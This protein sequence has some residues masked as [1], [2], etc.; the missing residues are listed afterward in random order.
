MASESF[1]DTTSGRLDLLRL[2][3][4]DLLPSDMVQEPQYMYFV[5]YVSSA[6]ADS[7]NRLGLP[8]DKTKVAIKSV[9]NSRNKLRMHVGD[10][11]RA[12]FSFD[13]PAA[14]DATRHVLQMIVR[15]WT[16]LDI[17]I[18]MPRYQAP[19]L[20]VWLEDESITAVTERFFSQ[21]AQTDQLFDLSG[22]VDPDLT[23]ARL[24]LDHN[25]RIIWTSNLAEHLSMNW[26]R[27]RRMLKVFEHK[28]WAHRHLTAPGQSPIPADVLDELMGTYNLLFPMFNRATES[29]LEKDGMIESFYSLG[30]CGKVPSRNWSDYKYWRKALH[31]L[32]EVLDEPPRGMQ[33]FWRTSKKDPNLLNVVLF[34]ISGVMVAILTI[35]SSVCGVL[36]VQYAIESRDIG[37]S[38]LELAVSQACADSD[39]AEKLPQYCHQSK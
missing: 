17:Q 19:G 26:T 5:H 3:W 15:L 27:K 29:L 32:S 14:E 30:T 8:S 23:A 36:S 35:V 16:M 38:Q 4:S 20:L 9:V 24:V 11:V 10:I 12:H 31:Q 2:F 1:P 25:I 33:Q 28:V 34:W 7:E 6:I 22:T 37:R 13:N 39:L 21:K 18:E